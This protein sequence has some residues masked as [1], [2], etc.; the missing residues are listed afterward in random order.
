M[1]AHFCKDVVLQDLDIA[2]VLQDTL[3]TLLLS[4]RPFDPELYEDEGEDDDV[5][6]EEGR[7]RLKLKVHNIWGSAIC[8]IIV[9]NLA[10]YHHHHR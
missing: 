6:D 4:C 5:L 9:I 8:I 10:W 2:V 1:Y 7:A 3:F